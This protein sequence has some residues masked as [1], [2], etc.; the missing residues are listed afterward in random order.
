MKNI[1]KLLALLLA[2][3]LF[4]AGCGSCALA[5]YGLER[6]YVDGVNASKVHLRQQPTTASESLG[7]IYTGTEVIVLSRNFSGWIHVRIGDVTGYM[8]ASYLSQLQPESVAPVA[9]VNNPNSTWSHLRSGASLEA[10]SVGRLYNDEVVYV[11]GELVSGWTY[12][13][14]GAQA[15]FVVSK[16]LQH[17]EQQNGQASAPG[18]SQTEVPN[19]NLQILGHA[20]NGDAIYCL[21]APDNAQTLFFVAPEGDHPVYRE[22]VNFDGMPDLAVTTSMGASNR[23]SALF[24]RNGAVYVP[25]QVPVLG[26]DLCNYRLYPEEK[27][28]LSATN[29]GAA[30]A[31]HDKALF[32][33]DGAELVLLRRATGEMP[34]DEYDQNGLI[35][36]AANPQL[37]KLKVVDYQSS[38][39]DGITLYENVVLLAAA[40]TNMQYE[41]AAFWQGLR[42]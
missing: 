27:L 29:D 10:M 18:Y 11:L 35:I 6:L 7:L 14:R 41:E 12:V 37:L 31:Y 25:V 8:S 40:E 32:R 1:R 17:S 30:G 4:A 16:F 22:D 34:V 28:L 20:A 26:Y 39:A 23:F 2:A 3:V 38:F 15:G 36:S 19:P 33:W 42:D 21:I 24:V 5:E 13:Q 9:Y